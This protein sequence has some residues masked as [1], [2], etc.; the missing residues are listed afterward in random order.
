MVKSWDIK[1]VKLRNEIDISKIIR[2][3]HSKLDINQ[4]KDESSK[5]EESLSN[6]EQ[7]VVMLKMELNGANQAFNKIFN[8]VED[9]KE[10]N[11][12]VL[13]GKKSVNCLSCGRGDIKFM[14][15]APIIKGKDG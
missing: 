13:V 10:I 11:R 5:L 3:I 2:E 1:I 15:A 14:P 12:N 4:F 8:D 7:A 9:L 6:I